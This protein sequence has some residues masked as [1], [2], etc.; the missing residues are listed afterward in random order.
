M[1]QN[2]RWKVWG[3]PI[4][5][6]AFTLMCTMLVITWFAFANVG[7]LDG[8]QWADVLAVAALGNAG[9][10]FTG[11]VRNSQR[12]A[13]AG[14]L[15]AFFLWTVRFLLI[16]LTNPQPI[17]TEGFFL[18]IGWAMVAGGSYVLERADRP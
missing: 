1:T 17:S 16:V 4:K 6:V 18:S 8:S 10:L 9:V 14:L 5:P 7:V 11:W 12:L 15:I 2:L 3:R 13:E